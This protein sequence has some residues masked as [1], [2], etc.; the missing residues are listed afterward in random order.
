MPTL[1][2]TIAAILFGGLTIYV[3]SGGADFG[4][5]VWDLLA[6]R[7]GEIPEYVDRFRDAYPEE[8]RD[9]GDITFVHAAN[10][11][12][13]FETVAFRA[14]QSRFDRFL[15]GDRSALSETE[16]RGME[17][18]YGEAGC[19]SCHS[20]PLQTDHEFHA[21]AMPQ[22]GPGKAD[23]RDGDYWRESGQQAFVED[24]GRGRVTMRP[25]DNYKFRTPSLRNVEL[26]GPWGH[27]GAYLTLEDVVRHH[28][29]PERS[30]ERYEV[31]RD[32]LPD[33]GVVLETTAEGAKLAHEPLPPHRLTGFLMRD[34]FVQRNPALRGRIAAANELE[35]KT[36]GDSEIRDL[37]AFLGSLTD[38]SSRDLSRLVPERVPS[39]L[40][41]ED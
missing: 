11:I 20:G 28:L 32:A 9:S 33:L 19:A 8:I 40:P 23:G 35:P 26:S 13:A 34:D 7:L 6:R 21:I 2:T 10:A 12:A 29:D 17:L 30:L 41:V 27:A 14:D 25:E 22:I 15:R 37:V 5:G 1:E 38:P 24:F 36:L 16:R 4:G 31:P 3:L 39:G 18:F